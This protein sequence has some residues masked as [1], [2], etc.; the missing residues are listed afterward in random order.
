MVLMRSVTSLGPEKKTAYFFE[1]QVMATWLMEIPDQKIDILRGIYADLYQKFS[2]DFD[3]R[4]SIH[5]FR[6]KHG[7]KVPLFFKSI[8]GLVGIILCMQPDPAPKALV[9]VMNFL[10]R[11]PDALSIS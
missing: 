5:H 4:G 1:D 9:S 6:T 7:V 2:I 10:K 8:Y 3:L 11:Y